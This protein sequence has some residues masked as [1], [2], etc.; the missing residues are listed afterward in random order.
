MT[1]CLLSGES[2]V[3]LIVSG[4]APHDSVSAVRGEFCSP[5]CERSCTPL[6][7]VCCQG[8]VLFTSLLV[9]LHPMTLCLL[10]GESSV[11]LIVSGPAPHYSVSAVRGE[12]CSP[13]CVRSCTPLLCVCCQGRVLFISL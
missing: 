11:H 6:L 3:H 7:C 2:S 12:F 9:V 5:H 8:R 13:H 10:S 4:P 1:L